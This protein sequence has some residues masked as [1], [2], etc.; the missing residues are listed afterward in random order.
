MR[1]GRNVGEFSISFKALISG[2]VVLAMASAIGVLGWRLHSESARLDSVH[3]EAENSARAEQ[4]ALDYST[5]AAQ[6]NFQ[7]LSAWRIRLTKGTSQEL[8]GRLTQA[9]TSMEQII[10]PLQ[11]VSTATPIA[12]KVRSENNGAYSVDCFVSILTKNS[13]APE[14]IQ[15]TA[16]YQLNIDSR[17]NWTITD[18]GGIGSA[19]GAGTAPR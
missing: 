1:S 5:A 10:V 13:Q 11:W 18:I 12:A 15:S 16:T 4:V 7:D 2:V 8:S 6:M 14:G 9:A 19:M 17:D 3:T